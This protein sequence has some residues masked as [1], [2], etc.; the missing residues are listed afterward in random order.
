MATT[1]DSASR[2]ELDLAKQRNGVN[3]NLIQGSRPRRFRATSLG[4][5]QFFR[6][7]NGKHNSG[8][9]AQPGR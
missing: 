1:V 3:P 9:L 2:T 7:K 5:I 8:Y 4:M 6:G